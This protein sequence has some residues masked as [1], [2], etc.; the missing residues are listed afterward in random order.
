MLALGT[1]MPEFELPDFDGRWISSSKSGVAPG[2]L[3]MF[4]CPHCPFVRHTRIEIGRVGSDFQSRGLAVYGINPNDTDAFPQDGP[5]GMKQEAA[6]A[7]YSFPYL[8]DETQAV[9][10][11][12]KAACTPE[13]YLFDAEQKLFYRGQLDSSRPGNTIPVTG[14]DLRTAADAMLAGR[15]APN[16]QKPSVGC[17]IKWKPGTEPNYF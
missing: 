5:E 17:S 10:R 13:F 7:G 12:Y 16:Y 1:V 4:L 15:I 14:L 9:A 8:R 2:T 3:V 6:I 11:L